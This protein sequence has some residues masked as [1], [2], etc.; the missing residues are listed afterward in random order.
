[1]GSSTKGDLFMSVSVKA[2]S[3]GSVAA[4]AVFLLLATA[5]CGGGS[6]ATPSDE[7]AGTRVEFDP[8]NFVDP[9]LSTNPYHPLQPGMQW[10]RGGTTEVGSRVV[11]QPAPPTRLQ[12]D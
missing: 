2:G 11:P 10:V 8:A 12:R 1:M 7:S 6:A 5:A 9:T 4:L 3:R